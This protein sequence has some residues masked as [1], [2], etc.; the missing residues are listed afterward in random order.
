PL[1]SPLGK[2]GTED[3]RQ[4]TEDRKGDK[5]GLGFKTAYQ[6][7]KIYFITFLISII[8]IIPFILPILKTTLFVKKEKKGVASKSSYVSSA[9]KR[10]FSDLDMYSA[11]VW[12]YLVP[13]ADNP[14]FGRYTKKLRESYEPSDSGEHGLYL[15]Y[16]A[17]MLAVYGL[18]KWRRGRRTPLYS[19][20]IRG[21]NP[22]VSPLGKGGT[23]DRRQKTEDRKGTPIIPP[24]TKGGEG[25]FIISFFWIMF[26]VSFIWSSPPFIHIGKIAVPMPSYFMYPIFP[27]F[28]NYARFVVVTLLCLG[29][30]AG[31][32][33]K[34]LLE[35]V[36]STKRKVLIVSLIVVFILA[37][38]INIPPFRNTDISAKTTPLVYKWLA[39][40]KGDFIITEYPL[41]HID[42]QGPYEY[43]FYQRVHKKRLF[44]GAPEGSPEYSLAWYLKDISDMKAPSAFKY[45]GIKYVIV[46]DDQYT[47]RELPVPLVPPNSG[48]ELVKTFKDTRVYQVVAKPSKVLFLHGSN[49]YPPEVF[50]DG[51]TRQ[52]AGEEP[53]MI[54][55]NYDKNKKDVKADIKFSVMAFARER[56]LKISLS[57]YKN[58]IKEVKIEP[59]VSTDVVL[60]NLKFKFG[61]NLI[62]FSSPEK[63]DSDYTRN[64]TF[65]FS[66]FNYEL[67]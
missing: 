40:E 37:E 43:F 28:R 29:I 16:T 36:K 64:V 25:G 61:E 67:K 5:W 11:R 3:R 46:H 53:Y 7:L 21:T 49:F 38:T 6:S 47:R 15:G 20:L 58:V 52:W 39:K 12:D 27:M 57:D 35:N 9:Y 59:F 48:F 51:K 23:E 41:I 8:I 56:M 4:K 13:I 62:L 63:A 33:I 60:K 31:Y 42:A 10:P 34:Y 19:P 32:G 18:I 24:L 30:L 14:I 45:L 54:F 2:G 50:D 17:I 44:N 26:F 65:A 55:L 1:V 66:D 22:L